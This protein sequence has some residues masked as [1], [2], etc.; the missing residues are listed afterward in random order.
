MTPTL[1]TPQSSST[2]HSPN[3]QGGM[4]YGMD[5]RSALH[6]AGC[7]SAAPG[8]SF[9]QRRLGS[10]VDSSTTIGSKSIPGKNF[11]QKGRNVQ[12]SIVSGGKGTG[13]SDRRVPVKRAKPVTAP[14]NL[15]LIP[16]GQNKRDLRTIEEIMIDMKNKTAS[17]QLQKTN[18][19]KT[20]N[21]GQKMR[22]SKPT[23]TTTTTGQ[24]GVNCSTQAIKKTLSDNGKIE[25]RAIDKS[26]ANDNYELPHKPRSISRNPVA[27]GNKQEAILPSTITANSK[28]KSF[29]GIDKQQVT[30]SSSD[31]QKR[32]HKNQKTTPQDDEEYYAQNYS[33]IISKLFNYD[34]SK[35]SDEIGELVDEALM[36]SSFDD[37]EREEK[38]SKRIAAY[39][40]KQEQIKLQTPQK[41]LKTSSSSFTFR[42]EM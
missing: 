9:N 36:E 5:Q 24:K 26:A 39:E 25:K 11:A 42:S 22:I 27:I 7:P 13:K 16:L 2:N 33:Q 28:P 12:S 35:Y 18:E 34:K 19:S 15:S 37:I 38:R 6:P 10:V 21:P 14:S 23:E 8:E 20:S 3:K 31:L 1:P 17:G 29:A 41:H 32:K 30:N 40:D 4:V